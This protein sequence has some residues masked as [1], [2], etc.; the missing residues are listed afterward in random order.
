LVEFDMDKGKSEYIA[1]GDRS[2][3]VILIVLCGVEFGALLS[4]SFAM[5]VL[6]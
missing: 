4:A 3:E 1:S 5:L 2:I 6:L